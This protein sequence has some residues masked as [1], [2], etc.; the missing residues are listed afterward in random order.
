MVA[1]DRGKEGDQEQVGWILNVSTRTNG[2]DK[3]PNRMARRVMMVT[4]GHL[5]TGHHNVTR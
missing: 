5:A 4:R 2:I 3:K 1:M